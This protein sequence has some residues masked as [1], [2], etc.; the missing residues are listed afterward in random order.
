MRV[1]LKQWLRP[2]WRE[3]SANDRVKF[4]KQT[5]FLT[6]GGA[7]ITSMREEYERWLQILMMA[8]AF[9]LLIVCANLAN[10]QLVRT[11][12]RCEGFRGKLIGERV[13]ES[14]AIVE[15]VHAKRKT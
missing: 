15:I 8:S 7:G 4:P 1:E 5:L 9:V 2:H 14:I 13:L 6:P 11:A 12:S 10:L 3:M